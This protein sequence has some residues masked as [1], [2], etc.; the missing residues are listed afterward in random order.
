MPREKEEEKGKA[1]FKRD[2]E[3]LFPWMIGER[4]DAFS[5]ISELCFFDVRIFLLFIFL[6]D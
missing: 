4:N 5:L 1:G 3:A 6:F 2:K